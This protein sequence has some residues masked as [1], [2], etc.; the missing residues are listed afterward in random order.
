MYLQ[1]S[2]VKDVVSKGGAL[3][4]RNRSGYT[5]QAS[6]RMALQ[7]LGLQMDPKSTALKLVAAEDEGEVT[8]ASRFSLPFRS[9]ASSAFSAIVG[10]N[11]KV[12]ISTDDSKIHRQHSHR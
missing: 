11:D 2:G 6:W 3:G 5:D 8:E 7:S 12:T 9:A 4:L 1:A 10:N